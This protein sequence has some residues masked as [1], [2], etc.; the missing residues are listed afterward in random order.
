MP[1]WKFFYSF[2]VHI[3]NYLN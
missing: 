3:L 2:E 1:I